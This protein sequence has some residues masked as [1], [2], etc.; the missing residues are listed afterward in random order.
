MWLK[1]ED[2]PTE[3]AFD[4]LI[5]QE[6][7]KGVGN[8]YN[9][10]EKEKITNAIDIAL[11]AKKPFIQWDN[12]WFGFAIGLVVMYFLIKVGGLL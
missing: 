2:T 11:K 1:Q 6:Y 8:D 10:W 5:K 7:F 9:K 3:K 4:Y 12:W